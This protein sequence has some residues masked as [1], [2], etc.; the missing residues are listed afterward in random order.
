MLFDD[1]ISPCLTVRRCTPAMGRSNGTQQ[2]HMR[3]FAMDVGKFGPDFGIAIYCPIV[4]WVSA[5]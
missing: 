4:K 1:N 3:C 2:N 5:K